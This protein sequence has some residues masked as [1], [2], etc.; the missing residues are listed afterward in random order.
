MAKKKIEPL[1][2]QEP[3]TSYGKSNELNADVIW[4]LFQETDK[5]FKET[6]QQFQETKQLFR[7]LDKKLEKSSHEWDEIKKELGGIGKGNGEIAEDY[8]YDTLSASMEVAGLKFDYIDRNIHRKRNNT[9]GEFDII[10]YNNYKV[11]IVE[12][13]YRF[14]YSY[15]RDFYHEKLKRFRTLFPEYKNYKLYGAIA[16]FTFDKE[17]KKEASE[18]GF[19]IFSQHNEKFKV[20][21]SKDFIPNEIK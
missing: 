1:V 2:V 16:A 5:R 15:V 9:E 18:Y 7:D 12:V 8:F 21:N 14:R 11:L 6:D 13:K 3:L 17:V 4:E 10:L 20:L 19:F